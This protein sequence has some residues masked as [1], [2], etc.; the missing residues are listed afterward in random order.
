M[1]RR[2]GR[3][4]REE[5]ASVASLAEGGRK[6]GRREEGR[7][8]EG[9]A[10]EESERAAWASGRETSATGRLCYF[11]FFFPFFRL[12]FCFR[13]GEK[14]IHSE[15]N[16]FLPFSSLS[17]LFE[18][19]TRG[20]PTYFFF[21]IKFQTA[22]NLSVHSFSLPPPIFSVQKKKKMICMLK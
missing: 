10:A 4:A 9:G 20:F 6:E 22:V 19:F 5:G 7:K 14:L 13:V 18:I 2:I 8:E 21:K 11:F 3:G 16:H 1:T 12:C 15:T 17:F